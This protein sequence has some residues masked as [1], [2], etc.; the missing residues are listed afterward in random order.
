MGAF[1]SRTSSRT[2]SCSGVVDHSNSRGTG[3]SASSTTFVGRPVNSLNCAAIS[4]TSPNVA[5]ISRNCACGSSRRGTCQ[6]Q[7]RSGSE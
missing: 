5:L 6:A 7:P 2:C 4:E 1:C 3:R